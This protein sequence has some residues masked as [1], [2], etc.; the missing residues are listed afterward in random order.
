MDSE[1]NGERLMKTDAFIRVTCD[2]CSVEMELEL[3]A[4]GRG[5]DER[6][7]DGDLKAAGWFDNGDKMLCD[8]CSAAGKEVKP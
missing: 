7:V 6:N 4:T 1:T 5:W 8:E 2:V 3:T